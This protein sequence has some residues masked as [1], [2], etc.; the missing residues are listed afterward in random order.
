MGKKGPRRGSLAYWHRARAKRL[1]PRL[2]H[3]PG[4]G[5][6]GFVGYKAGMADVVLVDDS[7]SPTKGQEVVVPVTVIETPPVF[8]YAV[9][10]LQLTPIG[11]KQVGQVVCTNAPKQAR[12]SVTVAKKSKGFDALNNKKFNELRLLVFTQ[13]WKTGLKK[14]P[15]IVEIALGG[16]TDKQLELA[17][18]LLGKELKA[19]DVFKQGSFVDVIAVTT[20]KGWQGVVKRFGVALNP[21]KATAHRRKGGTLGGETQARVFY[22]VP[23]PGQTGFHRRTDANKRILKISTDALPPLHHYGVVKN[24]YFLVKGSVP[25]PVKRL[26]RMRNAENSEIKEPQLLAI[27]A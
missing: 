21:R 13:P 14:K 25:G 1:V 5:V 23:R 3:S 10:A 6:T 2:R 27:N 8:V 4:Q 24:T 20:G 18:N 7:E 12:R 11:W 19:E 26:V 9:N 17:K 16:E 15:E 22:S